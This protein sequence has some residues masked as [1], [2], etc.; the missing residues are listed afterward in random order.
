MENAF[1]VFRDQ[2]Q[3]AE[4]V[5]ASDHVLLVIYGEMNWAVGSGELSH[6]EYGH[7]REMIAPRI[8]SYEQEL[9]DFILAEQE[10]A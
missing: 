9:D 2:I 8:S 4:R 6:A 5:G 7:L 3:K 10:E 1:D